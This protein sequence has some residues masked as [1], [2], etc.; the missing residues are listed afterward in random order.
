MSEE[1]PEVIAQDAIVVDDEDAPLKEAHGE[2]IEGP[3]EV[4]DGD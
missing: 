3:Q 2:Y 4:E 1:F